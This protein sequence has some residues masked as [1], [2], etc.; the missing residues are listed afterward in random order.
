M[1]LICLHMSSS[2]PGK[3]SSVKPKGLEVFACLLI[4]N[5]LLLIILN[6]VKWHNNLLFLLMICII[7][8]TVPPLSSSELFSI[9]IVD[10]VQNWSKLGVLER[11]S[12]QENMPSSYGSHLNKFFKGIPE[13]CKICSLCSAC[14]NM[15]VWST[16]LTRVFW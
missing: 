16:S 13:H 8:G 2:W 7:K 9:W 11:F 6:I 5:I 4:F 1:L 10:C 14:Q 12:I 3:E 15:K